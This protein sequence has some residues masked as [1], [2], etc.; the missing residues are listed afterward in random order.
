ML[1]RWHSRLSLRSKA[2]GITVAV[3]T[4]VLSAVAGTCVVQLR[5][6]IFIE[7]QRRGRFN[8]D[9]VLRGRRSWR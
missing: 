8:G 7:Q 5:K 9:G 4:I 1:N 6:Q 3:T 2:I